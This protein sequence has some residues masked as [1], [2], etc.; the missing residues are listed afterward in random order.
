MLEKSQPN[1]DL[2]HY[3]KYV[4]G[5]LLLA[6]HFLLNDLIRNYL[7]TKHLIIHYNEEQLPVGKKC[8]YQ[9]HTL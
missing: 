1:I 7:F 9:K 8:T 6:I 4:Q 5:L 3:L 2:F